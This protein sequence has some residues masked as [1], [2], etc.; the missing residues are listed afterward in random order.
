[1]DL[2]NLLT[3]VEKAR[4]A[5]RDDVKKSME[6][7]LSHSVIVLNTAEIVR[8]GRREDAELAAAYAIAADPTSPQPQ[9]DNE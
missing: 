9:Q 4:R 2:D 8:E 6:N 1:M 5:E 7:H 3:S